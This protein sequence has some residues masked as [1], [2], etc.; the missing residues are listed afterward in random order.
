M[1]FFRTIFRMPLTIM[2]GITFCLIAGAALY[3]R[4]TVYA[5]Y[6]TAPLEEPYISSVFKGVRD[7][8]YPWGEKKDAHED[9]LQ[10]L[11]SQVQ[12]QAGV[13]PAAG[14]IADATANK[15]AGPDADPNAGSIAG[16]SSEAENKDADAASETTEKKEDA[17]EESEEETASAEDAEK[18]SEETEEKKEEGEGE[19][20][21]KA[22]EPSE[23][24][25]ESSE[26]EEAAKEEEENKEP[27]NPNYIRADSMPEGV[28]S[29]V[30]EAVDYGVA[31]SRYLS[32][33]DTVYNTDEGGVFAQNGD[34]Y[35]FRDVNDVYFSD[36]LIIG[37][38]RTVGLMEFGGMKESTYFIAK[39]ST[40]VY[41]LFT[42]PLIFSEPD[43]TRTS[44]TLLDL[45]VSKQFRKIYLSVGVNELGI[46]DT[47][48]FYESYKAAVAVI[49]QLQPDAIIY[50]QGIMHVSES[51]SKS[52]KVFNN[53]VVVQRN[54]AIATLANG[55]DIF[56]IDMN[57]DVCDENGNLLPELTS[58]GIHLKA[59][60]YEKWHEF[61]LHHA[62]YRSPDDFLGTGPI[63]EGVK[64]PGVTVPAEE[65]E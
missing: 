28:N 25:E 60:G 1:K 48:K 50:I 21:A 20:A 58:D 23:E 7:G 22:E 34:Y 51:K 9:E 4:T 35:T 10:A 55:H 36:A 13:A 62:I 41:N 61:L 27:E 38:S 45:L 16:E 33:A 18:T 32:P 57:P 29:P 19:D 15:I 24:K 59:S 14:G 54:K 63:D 2:L 49:R 44:R 6:E 30:M 12:Q 39:E 37:D 47:I 64:I 3:G 52:D 17:A 5:E 43:G 42:K 46:P 31:G 65:G 53:T 11:L 56:Y 8:I 40:N 26:T